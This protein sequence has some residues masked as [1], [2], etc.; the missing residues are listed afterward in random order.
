MHVDIYAYIQ[1]FISASYFCFIF[2]LG[3]NL[4][5]YP[6]LWAESICNILI[7]VFSSSS[8]SIFILNSGKSQNTTGE[9]R[10]FIFIPSHIV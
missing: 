1:G 2:E 9:S 3:Q 7:D 8:S 6:F 10:I 4:K 5:A